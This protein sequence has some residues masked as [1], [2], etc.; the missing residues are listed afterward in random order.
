[1]DYVSPVVRSFSKEDIHNNIIASAT[2]VKAF[3][4]AEHTFTCGVG[5]VF[6]VGMPPETSII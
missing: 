5:H 6:A 3:C 1:M 2:C 4:S